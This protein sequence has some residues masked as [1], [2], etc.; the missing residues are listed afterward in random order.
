V[1]HLKRSSP[2]LIQISTGKVTPI[3][4]EFDKNNTRYTSPT[5]FEDGTELVG[6]TRLLGIETQPDY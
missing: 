4:K 1:K 5:E 2:V 6:G 3:L